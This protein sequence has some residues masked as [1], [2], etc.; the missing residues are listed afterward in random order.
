[1]SFLKIT[2]KGDPIKLVGNPPQ[3]GEMLPNATVTDK[4]GNAVQLHD[5]IKDTT[6][7]S[8]V[9]N[10]T[11]SVCSIQTQ[12]FAEGTKDKDYQFLSV[13]INTPEEWQGWKS[14]H[15]LD[16]VTLSDTDRD[17]GQA[18]GLIMDGLDLLARSVFVVDAQKIVKYVQVV[19]EG[20]DEPSYDDA[21]AAAD[22]I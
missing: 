1:M 14:E 4:D 16:M 12:R 5:L 22:N 2:F 21:I 3:V 9:P 19:P 11:T 6:I 7:L 15:D 13:S 18:T 8:V 20:T 17:F 10:V